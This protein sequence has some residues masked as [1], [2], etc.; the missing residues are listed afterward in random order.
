MVAPFIV[1]V[2][3]SEIPDKPTALVHRYSFNETD[4]TTVTDSVGGQNGTVE[5]ADG[6]FTGTH[7]TTPGGAE[8][9]GA[10]YVDLPNGLISALPKAVT[11][12]L[13][14]S[15]TSTADW[16]RFFDFGSGI[17]GEDVTGNGQTYFILTPQNGNTGTVHV[18]YTTSSFGGETTRLNPTEVIDPIGD[19]ERH[20][21]VT[22][23]S[24]VGITKLYIDGVLVGEQMSELAGEDLAN[25]DD[26]NNWLGRSQWGNPRIGANYN[27]FRIHSGI[28]NLE[29]VAAS[30]A[31]GPDA[32]IVVPS[33]DEVVVQSVAY[34]AD[35][36]SV[37]I[38][39]ET[40]V[41]KAYIVEY[42]DSLTEDSWTAAPEGSFTATAT[43]TTYTDASI[44]TETGVRFYRVRVVDAP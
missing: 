28:M 31:A 3:V 16:E 2:T 15:R 17:N 4:G 37:T 1:P 24:E 30:F 22:Y 7:L 18:A 14:A 26:V 10:A 34:N 36:P 8:G 44:T 41:D 21:V 32:G 27:E 43:T 9:S 35:A 11:F 13:W 12:E 40:E 6:V 23:D 5:G 38:V 42:S 29:G 20:Y 39:I 33:P 19:V 25:L